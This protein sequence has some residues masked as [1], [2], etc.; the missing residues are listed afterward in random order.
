[1][2]LVYEIRISFGN[3]K[4]STRDEY[5]WTRE[6]WGDSR[7]DAQVFESESEAVE[8]AKLEFKNVKEQD[9]FHGE[10]EVY[11]E[12]IEINEDEDEEIDTIVWTSGK[13]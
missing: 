7:K 1:M 8:T 5:K 4:N 13:F 6:G 10:R 12:K 2:K 11:V 3:F 9:L